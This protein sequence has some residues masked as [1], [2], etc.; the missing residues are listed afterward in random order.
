MHNTS[1]RQFL[2]HIPIAVAAAGLASRAASADPLGF[3]IGCQTYPVRD[4]LGKDF[5]GTLR[6]LASIDQFRELKE[7]LD[8]RI[9]FAKELGLKQMVL[10]TFGLRQDA[11]MADWV[12]AAHDL[13][14]I[15][16][17]V[18]KAGLQLGF[19][20]HNFE[21]KQIDGELVYDKLMSEL[22]SKLV[23]MQFQVSV[24]S[25]G[26]EAAS[27]FTKYPGRYISIHLQD[28]SAADKKQVAV[29]QGDVDWK[30]LFA[31]AKTAGVKNYFVELNL[32]AMKASYPF[33]HALKV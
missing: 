4:A 22:D 15:G 14:Q 3:P 29:G 18:R 6:E 25:L 28:W 12:Q 2:T 8:D 32:D 33:L 1:R 7:N 10:S 11:T 20:N 27:F 31:A 26:Y 19:H 13:N 23:K 30:K 21:F 16:D 9:A 24:I 5:N 17:K